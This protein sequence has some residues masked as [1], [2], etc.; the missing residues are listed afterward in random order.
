MDILHFAKARKDNVLQNVNLDGEWGCA[1]AFRAQLGIHSSNWSEEGCPRKPGQVLAWIW[2]LLGSL[3]AAAAPPERNRTSPRLG[4]T[5]PDFTA[6]GLFEFHYCYS[7]CRHERGEVDTSR[8]Q[9]LLS[10]NR[11][12]KANTSA[13]NGQSSW[14]LWMRWDGGTQAGTPQILERQ[15][16]SSPTLG[17]PGGV[18][19]HAWAP[20][21]HLLQKSCFPV[22]SHYVPLQKLPVGYSSSPEGDVK[23]SLVLLDRQTQIDREKYWKS[24]LDYNNWWLKATWNQFIV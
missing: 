20:Q 8:A 5:H 3:A 23:D 15:S 13:E 24:P 1:G 7:L 6:W 12:G 14:S 21:E 22:S 2:C 18:P 4:P 10:W 16:P 9:L 17:S 11:W 19:G